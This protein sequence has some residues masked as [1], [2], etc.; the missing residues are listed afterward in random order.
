[1]VSPPP[2][3][4][5]EGVPLFRE[6]LFLTFSPDMVYFWKSFLKEEIPWPFAEMP[7]PFWNM[8]TIPQP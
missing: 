6:L 5:A 2:A 3:S 4:M 8:T 7:F 1:M